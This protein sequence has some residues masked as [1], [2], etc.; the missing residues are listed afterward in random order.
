MSV[1]LRIHPGAESELADAIRWHEHNGGTDLATDFALA[2][3]E[4]LEAVQQAPER[5]P[6]IWA[7]R[8]RFLIRRFRYGIFYSV[9]P[10]EVHVLAIYHLS[11]DPWGWQNRT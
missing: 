1:P 6:V 8:R 7:D 11:R 4:G 2:V 3:E 9:Q 10:D 5:Y